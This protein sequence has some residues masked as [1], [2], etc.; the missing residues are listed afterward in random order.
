[1]AAPLERWPKFARAQSERI[2]EYLLDLAAAVP[3]RYQNLVADILI[4]RIAHILEETLPNV[5]SRLVCGETYMDGT[6]AAVLKTANTADAALTLM[7]RFKRKNKLNL[8]WLNASDIRK[9]VEH[10]I[11]GSEHALKVVDRYTNE[12]EEIRIVRNHVA[13]ST[14]DTRR[15]FKGMIQ[16][17]YGSQSINVSVGK[18]VLSP[19]SGIVPISKYN[20]VA[21]ILV[22]E[23]CKAP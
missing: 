6:N 7:K 12:L 20:K 19:H 11:D 8:K 22:K 2:D 10:L 18:F 3:E 21:R 23:I 5:F 14:P 17:Y 9:N 16:K 4:I 15:S 1:M 13:H